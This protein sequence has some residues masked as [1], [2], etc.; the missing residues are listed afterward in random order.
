[1]KNPKSD[2]IQ[3][4]KDVLVFNEKHKKGVAVWYFPI[5]GD[6]NGK[7]IT[8]TASGA[9]L[10]SAGQAVINLENKSGYVALN[11]VKKDNY[12]IHCNPLNAIDFVLSKE[13]RDMRLFGDIFLEHWR[14][15]TFDEDY[16]K[17][18]EKTEAG[19][20]KI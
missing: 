7:I 16:C 15:G 10:D 18:C 19:E 4:E 2:K 13:A 9:F 1:M 6:N 14:E 20:L 3:N 8:K 12:L 11:H 5:I 17:W